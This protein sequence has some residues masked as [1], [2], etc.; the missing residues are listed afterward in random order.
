MFVH[1]DTKI[2]IDLLRAT[3]LYLMAVLSQQPAWVGWSLIICAFIIYS[4]PAAAI[5][6]AWSKKETKSVFFKYTIHPMTTM[7]LL[8]ALVY[9]VVLSWRVIMTE[10]GYAIP[11]TLLYLAATMY[12]LLRQHQRAEG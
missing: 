11:F 9:S 10:M 5:M 4:A 6:S 12:N 7:A 8:A 1:D 2:A 3:L